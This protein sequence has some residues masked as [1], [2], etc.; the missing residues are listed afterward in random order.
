[1]VN[2]NNLTKPCDVVSVCVDCSCSQTRVANERVGW[3][4]KP[5]LHPIP[6]T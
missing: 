5:Y 6:Y 2:I 3:S 1:M 4:P